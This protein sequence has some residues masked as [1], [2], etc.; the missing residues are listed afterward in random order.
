MIGQLLAKVIGTQNERELKRLQPRVGQIS[1]LEPSIQP[2]SDDQLHVEVP[3]VQHPPACLAHDRKG[4]DEQV[5]ERL[6][7]GH[8]LLEL[9]RFAAEFFV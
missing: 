2:L 3:H 5:V 4:F 8:A 1:A 6:A 7:V 9:G